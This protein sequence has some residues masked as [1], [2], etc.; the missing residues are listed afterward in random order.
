MPAV[1]PPVPRRVKLAAWRLRQY[2]AVRRRTLTCEAPGCLRSWTDRHH[3]FGR[4]AEPWASFHLVLV[5][6]CDD[7]H[8]QVTGEVGR[9]LDQILREL[10]RVQAAYRLERWVAEVEALLYGE[11]HLVVGIVDA[12]RRFEVTRELAERRGIWPTG[13]EA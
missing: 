4:R 12:T 11:A 9:G 10:L 8:R 7:H 6:L 5:L 2:D 1:R 3:P 13:W